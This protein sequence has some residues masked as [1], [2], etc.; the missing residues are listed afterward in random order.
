[1]K[2]P[3]GSN[4][5]NQ[6]K[7]N[8]KKKQAARST[9]PAAPSSNASTTTLVQ[10]QP[11]PYVSNHDA[12]SV[13]SKEPS[14]STTQES[15][16]KKQPSPKSN[17]ASPTS[18]PAPDVF[19]YL[20]DDSSESDS[21]SDSSVNSEPPQKRKTNPPPP[22]RNLPSTRTNDDSP[23]TR[24]GRQSSFN[25]ND[26]GISIREHSPDRA[27]SVA[28]RESNDDQ[29]ATPPNAMLSPIDWKFCDGTRPMFSPQI[30][31]AYNSYAPSLL[32]GEN[33]DSGDPFDISVP[34][35]FYIPSREKVAS[36]PNSPVSPRDR[37]RKDSIQRKRSQP[38][39]ESPRMTS[40]YEQRSRKSSLQQSN[41]ETIVP[42]VYRKFEVLNH[43]IL[44]NLQNEIA[45]MEEDLKKLDELEAAHRAASIRSPSHRKLSAS[46]QHDVEPPS[47][48]TLRF[49]QQELL[50]QVQTK[51]QQY[52]KQKNSPFR[53]PQ[54]KKIWKL[55]PQ[56]PGALFI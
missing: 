37:T 14:S 41:D 1:M 32:D 22:L 49:Q 39:R 51:I 21:D 2:M 48:S 40:G 55:T 3:R 45:Q 46:S 10:Q 56:R 53:S 19:E 25:S 35:T 4:A 11:V 30:I 44:L 6:G 42:P 16:P 17:Q 52:S 43:R 12:K 34:E 24:S 8:R 33:S 28:S 50:E 36:S 29:P 13:P 47:V 26:S 18:S 9:A 38:S 23:K 54:K 7:N 5:S 31:G 20:D 15:L 27:S